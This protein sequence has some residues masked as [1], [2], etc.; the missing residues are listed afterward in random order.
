M[1]EYKLV[2]Q[3]VPRVDAREKVMGAAVYTSDIEPPGMLYHGKILRSPHPHARIIKVD[4]ERAEK[5]PGVGAV[6]IGKDTPV[7]FGFLL[8]DEW[9]LAVEKVRFVGEPVV[10]VAAIDEDIAEEALALINVEYEVL[11]AVFDAE[12]AIKPG[13][14][15]VQEGGNIAAKYHILRGDI[16][17]GFNEADYIFEDRFTTHSQHH[18]YMEPYGVIASFDANGKLTVWVGGMYPSGLRVEIARYLNI[19]ESKVRIICPT[20]GG[21]FGN[22]ITMKPEMP[23]CALLAK[24]IGKPVKIERTREEE[25]MAGRPRITSIWQLKTGVKKDG[26]IVAFSKKVLGNCGAYVGITPGLM[27]AMI[28]IRSDNLY[29][30]VNIETEGT[31][32]YTNATPMKNFRGYGSVQSTFAFESQM[33]I[34]AE[35]LGMDPMELRLKNTT[36]SGDLTVH[37]WKISSCG[38]DECI[39]KVTKESGWKEKKKKK[40]FGKGVGMAIAMH[41]SDIRMKTVEDVATPNYFGGAV[42]FVKIME[43][44]RIQI[45]TGYPDFGQGAKTTLSIIAA[46]VLGVPIDSVELVSLDT[47]IT[48]YT[49]GPWGSMFTLSG[50]MAVKLAAEDAKKQLFEVASEMLEIAPSDLDVGNGEVFVKGSPWKQVSISAV[51]KFAAYSRG[52]SMIMGKGVDERNTVDIGSPVELGT[53]RNPATLFY[54]HAS[55]APYF[56]AN[57]AE[58]EVDTETGVVRVLKFTEADDMGKVINHLGWEGQV[59]GGITQGMGFALSEDLTPIQ[60]KYYPLTFMDYKIPSAMDMPPIKLIP[61]ETKE[62]QGPFGAKGGGESGINVA[63]TAIANAVYDAVGIRIKDLPLTPEKILKALKERR[64]I[65]Q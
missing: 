7:K 35:K 62:P 64:S 45:N 29:R 30:H 59:Q 37:G 9:A 48:P 24:K 6:I 23:I 36:K 46:E 18:C 32:V 55:S 65:E 17:K 51:A 19:G 14:V 1:D 44:G 34:I 5:L 15:P 2:G 22:K 10:A 57:V 13:A 33:D 61:V 60:G 41:E 53:T 4:K 49:L 26:R 11:P 16:E 8:Q 20:I 50:G 39:Q 21:A 27:V 56:Y 25:F 63:P 52:G 28:G 47:D 31:L 38:L 54:G 58:V 3:R 40:Q 43:D 42:I 12:E